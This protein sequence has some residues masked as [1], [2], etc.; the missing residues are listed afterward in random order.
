MSVTLLPLSIKTGL[1][2]VRLRAHPGGI[3]IWNAYNS[4]SGIFC[5][6]A[7]LARRKTSVTS[8]ETITM[9]SE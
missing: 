4:P 9:N 1:S 8:V 3:G 2:R 5:S 7:V 6:A